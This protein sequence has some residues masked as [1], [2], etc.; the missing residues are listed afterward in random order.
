MQRHRDVM[1]T[2]SVVTGYPIGM[3]YEYR[4]YKIP[5]SQHY[6][7]R[8]QAPDLTYRPGYNIP[9]NNPGGKKLRMYVTQAPTIHNQPRRHYGSWWGHYHVT[10]RMPQT[11]YPPIE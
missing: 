4:R 10:G 8:Q 5:S 1:D 7:Q 11:T 2:T 6:P 9:G 3:R